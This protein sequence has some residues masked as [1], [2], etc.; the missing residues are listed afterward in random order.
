ML[1]EITI[2]ELQKKI[3]SIY[4]L[5]NLAAMRARDLNDGAP[6]L[7]DVDTKNPILIALAEIAEEKIRCKKE[8]ATKKTVI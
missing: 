2:E 3:G 1:N 7:V 6:K 4:K 8:D 5:V